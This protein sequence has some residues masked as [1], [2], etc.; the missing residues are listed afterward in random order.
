MHS[1]W[2]GWRGYQFVVVVGKTV[3]FEQGGSEGKVV[4]ALVG[5]VKVACG[6]IFVGLICLPK[7]TKTNKQKYE[8][9]GMIFAV[10][11]SLLITFIR[12]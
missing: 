6:Q 10:R 3:L 12:L 2:V 4:L 8:M 1:H 9:S 5:C 11:K 7:T